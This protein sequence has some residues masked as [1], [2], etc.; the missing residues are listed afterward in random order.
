MTLKESA[1]QGIIPGDLKVFDAHAHLGEGEYSSAFLYT[2]PIAKSL[3]LSGKIGIQAIAASSLKALGG[4][5]VGGNEQIMEYCERFPKEVFAYIFFSAHHVRES[6]SCIER[7]KDH[8]NFIGVKIHPRDDHAYIQDGSFDALYEYAVKHDIL[9]LCHTWQ[10]EPENDPANFAMVLKRFPTLKLLLGHMGGTRKGC[11]SSIALAN[12]YPNVY[13]DINGSLYSEI[14]IEELVKKAPLEKFIFS[15]DQTFNDPRIIMGRVL[16]SDLADDQ[17]RS[18]L[19][20]NF[21]KVMGWN[22]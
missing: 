5:T 14:W 10:T 8:K 20:Y 3:Q 22:D 11:Y 12:E 1:L 9:I 4:Q 19:Y 15:T 2:L 7:Y 13:L 6:L 16:L 21:A 17:K 18:I